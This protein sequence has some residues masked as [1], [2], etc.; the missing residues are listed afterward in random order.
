MNLLKSLYILVILLLI[1]GAVKG[2][3]NLLT[4]SSDTYKSLTNEIDQRDIDTG[5]ALNF[6][7]DKTSAVAVYETVQTIEHP[8]GLT[9]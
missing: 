9:E 3:N 4:S 8:P 5:N 7:G 1:F 6:N 2:M